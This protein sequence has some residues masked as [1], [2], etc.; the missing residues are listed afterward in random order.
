MNSS[1]TEEEA[2]LQETLEFLQEELEQNKGF[3]ITNKYGG[4]GGFGLVLFVEEMSDPSKKYAIKAQSIINTMTGKVN[5]NLLKQCEDEATILRSCDHKNIVQIHSDF[6]IGLYHFIQMNLCQCSLQDWIDQNTQPINDMLFLHYVNQIIDG[7]EYLHNKDYVLRDLSVRNILITTDNIVKLCDFGLAKKYDDLLKSKVLYTQTA[8]GVFLYFPPELQED[9]NAQK[10]QIKQTKKGDI[11]AFGICLM[12]LG[13]I[14]YNQL[15]NLQN[16]NYQVSDAPFLSESSNQLIKFI[17]NKD[18]QKRPSFPEIREKIFSLY[19]GRN[20]MLNESLGSK[21]TQSSSGSELIDVLQSSK[22]KFY[23]ESQTILTQIT[24]ANQVLQSPINQETNR[25]LSSSLEQ[26][27]ISNKKDDSEKIPEVQLHKKAFSVQVAIDKNIDIDFMET[28]IIFNKYS[29]HLKEYPNSVQALLTL[30]YL[31][32]YAFSNYELSKKYFE[33]AIQIDGNEIDA[34][35]GICTC[36]ILN[37]ELKYISKAKSYLNKCLSIKKQYWRTYYIYAWLLILANKEKEALNY[38]IQGL[39]IENQSVEL[40]SLQLIQYRHQNQINTLDLAEKVANLNKKHNPVVFQRLGSFYSNE[41]QNYTKAI[42]FY[43]QAYEI[44]KKDLLTHI[45]LA[46]NYYKN[47]DSWEAEQYLINAQILY[48]ENSILLNFLGQKEVDLANQE[49]LFKKSISLDPYNKWALYNLAR[50]QLSLGNFESAIKYYKKVL[51]QD[52]EDEQANAGIGLVLGFYLQDFN[53]AIEHYKIAINTNFLKLEYLINLA[54]LHLN[55]KDLDSAQSYINQCMQINSNTP[56]IYEILCKIE[57]QKGN[58]LKAV[59]YIQKQMELE[60]QNADVYHRL[61]QLYHQSNPEEAK[62]NYIKSLQLDPKQKMVNYRLGLLEKEFTQQIKYYQNELIIN[63][64]NIEAISAVAMSLQCQ[65]KYDLALQFLQKGLKR[66]PN[67]Y[68]LYKNIA[69]VY[70]IQRKYYESIESYKQALNLNAQN[71][72]LLFLLANTYFLSGQTENAID[73]YKEAIKLNPSYHQSYFELGKIYEELKQY[74]Q[75]VEQFQVYLQYQPNSSETYYKIG[76]I[77]YLHFKNIQKAQICFIQSIQLNPNNNSSCYRYLGLIQ[78]ELGDYK[79]AKQNFLQAIEINKNEEDLYFILAQISY[80]YFKDIWQAIEYL[81][82]Y[83]QLFPNQE[84]QEQLLNEWYLKVNNTV[85]ARETYEKQIQENPQN[86][87]A[88][89]KIASIEYQVKNYHKSIF[90]YNKVLEIDP[91]NKLS[92]YNIGLC[93]KQL[94]KYEK[95]V[96][97]FQNVIKIYQSFSLAYYQIGEIEQRYLNNPKKAI[98][99][100]RKAI[101]LKG[102]DADSYFYLGLA[103]DKIDYKYEALECF[104]KLLDCSPKYPT[105]DFCKKYISENIIVKK[106][107]YKETTLEENDCKVF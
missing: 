65:G 59:E 2:I 58:S 90:Q 36:I 46:D 68:I 62:K 4:R 30:G 15:L 39:Q 20:G 7:I 81:E 34:Y 67:N 86:I 49:Q 70:S 33:E 107:K 32:A 10:S 53:Q 78:N 38:L 51:E 40:L 1:Q 76:M 37:R 77:E 26:F 71:I 60:P 8:R 22:L 19:Y 48:P 29:K 12:I 56:K 25:K 55:I 11:W 44:N 35:L 84:K 27:P 101:E 105:A 47:K 75:A 89:M 95:A 79:Q 104:Q 97:Y 41:M 98:K 43:K 17:L 102:Q 54:N 85:R 87:S 93:F 92:L 9:L 82:K 57:Q 80:N 21:S 74:Q 24:E 6:V 14:K 73:N 103:F 94:E 18:P 13:G 61:G 3:K 88:I 69:N 31:N 100:L 66:D 28:N 42:Y 64:Q 16:N 72:E 5:K 23:S 99:F 91:N 96:E 106:K 83:L 63:P 50:C 52:P 45:H